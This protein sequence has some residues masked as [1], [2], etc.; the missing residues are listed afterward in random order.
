MFEMPK[1]GTWEVRS[2]WVVRE[3]KKDL[4]W[5]LISGAALCGNFAVESIEFTTFQEIGPRAGRGGAG[6]AQWTGP[7][8]RNFE[9]WALTHGLNLETDEASYGFAVF[10]FRGADSTM[11][12]GSNFFDMGRQLRAELNLETATRLIHEWYER[13]QEVLDGT[14][15][16]GPERLRYAQR[17]LKGAQDGERAGHVGF[18]DRPAPPP[19][20]PSP[21]LRPMLRLTPPPTTGPEVGVL[22]TLLLNQG[23]NPGPVDEIF[24][25]LTDLAVRNFQRAKGLEIDGIVGPITWAALESK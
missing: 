11:E 18:P 9:R 13:P 3:L 2:G 19:A 4:N 7:R 16:S 5:P 23:F 21:S 17:A 8:R 14:F 10:E 24:G 6:W 20:N 15:K 25:S 22:Q 12:K 1:E